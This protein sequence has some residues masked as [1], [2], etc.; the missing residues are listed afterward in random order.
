MNRNKQFGYVKKLELPDPVE[1]VDVALEK[2]GTKRYDVFLKL[3]NTGNFGNVVLDD[4][5]R[6]FEPYVFRDKIIPKNKSKYSDKDEDD[7]PYY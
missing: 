7:D 4:L 3:F 5:T 1:D 6:K 2:F